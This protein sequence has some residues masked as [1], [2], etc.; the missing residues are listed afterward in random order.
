[1]STARRQAVNARDT[2]N[3]CATYSIL[4]QMHALHCNLLQNTV[5]CTLPASMCAMIPMFLYVSRGTSRGAAASTTKKFR[6]N[7]LDRAGYFF[8]NASDG[9]DAA[10]TRKAWAAGLPVF[11]LCPH[12]TA[13]CKAPQLKLDCL[14][15]QMF[16][17]VSG[18]TDLVAIE[19]PLGPNS[20]SGCR[21][22]ACL[23]D[24]NRL[25]TT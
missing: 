19:G 14:R 3:F 7:R 16:L 22:L 8:L 17:V 24:W 18:P 5:D 23:E 12:L 10:F 21:I 11:P 4:K 2:A 25:L 13:A 6:D 9:P 20:M 15:W 1:M